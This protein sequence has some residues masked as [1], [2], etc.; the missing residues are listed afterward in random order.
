MHSLGR[1]PDF[2]ARELPRARPKFPTVERQESGFQSDQKRRTSQAAGKAGCCPA[3]DAQSIR[4][5]VAKTPAYLG[6]LPPRVHP[7][8]HVFT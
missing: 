6:R 7:L 2:A 4:G 5:R 3:T 8:S 1:P